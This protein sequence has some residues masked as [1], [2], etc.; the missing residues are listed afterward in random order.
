MNYHLFYFQWAFACAS[1]TIVSGSV[2][3]RCKLEAYFVYS[4]VITVW[5]Y[6]VVA[7]WSW[8]EGWLSAFGPEPDGYLFHGKAFDIEFKS[9]DEI[10]LTIHF[11][12]MKAKNRIIISISRAVE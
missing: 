10:M 2:A 3:E 11:D 6:P 9:V 4:A 7:H 1:S 8:G 12:T 5:I